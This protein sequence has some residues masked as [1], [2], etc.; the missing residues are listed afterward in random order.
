LIGRGCSLAGEGSRG[1]NA[2]ELHYP[3]PNT[4]LELRGKKK[5]WKN[6]ARKDDL[7]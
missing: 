4:T 1:C 7:G 3:L 6:K 2:Q 5:R